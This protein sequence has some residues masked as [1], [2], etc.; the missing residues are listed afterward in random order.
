MKIFHMGDWHIGKVVNGFSMIEDQG[1]IIDELYKQIIKEKPDLLIIAGDLY[2]RSIPP[3]QAVELLNESFSKIVLDFK[4][5]IIAIAGNHDGSERVEFGSSL[6]EKSGLHIFGSLKK[7]INKV[8]IEDKKGPIN[9]YPIPF[10]DVA[11]IRD[12]YEDMTIKNFDDGMRKVVEE[13]MKDFNEEERNIAIA[14]G[15]VTKVKEGEVDELEESTSEKPLSIGGTDYIDVK[16]FDKFN[17]TALGHLHGPQKV[18]SDKVRYSGSLMKYSFSEIKQKKGITVVDIDENGEVTT[19]VILLKQK[20]NYREV[21][22][23]LEEIITK[24]ELDKEN[25]EDYIR[26]ILEDKGE[27][28]DPMSKLRSIYP[29]IMELTKVEFINRNNIDNKAIANVKEKS[30]LVLFE[31]FYKDITGEPCLEEEGKIMQE[32]IKKL[33]REDY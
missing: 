10:A 9:F 18:G 20:K 23:T 29:N 3:V 30:K 16:V 5:P 7:Q 1:Y 21:I 6:L 13:I 2:D 12:L 28:L 27:I 8:V 22:G 17:Y 19:K 11:V 24:S 26:V 4:T 31:D 33:E 14:H 15:Y 32:I 25:K